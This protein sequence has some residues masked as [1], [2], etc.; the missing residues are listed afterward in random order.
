MKSS[1]GTVLAC[2]FGESGGATN[3]MVPRDLSERWI[4]HDFAGHFGVASSRSPIDR[5]IYRHLSNH[6]RDPC[7]FL[8]SNRAD[9]SWANQHL[10]KLSVG[11]MLH[12]TPPC[13]SNVPEKK[14]IENCVNMPE[15]ASF[16]CCNRKNSYSTPIACTTNQLPS[17]VPWNMRHSRNRWSRTSRCDGTCPGALDAQV[18][19]FPL[20]PVLWKTTKH[21]KSINVVPEASEFIS[22]HIT[23]Y[24]FASRYPRVKQ[25]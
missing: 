1:K 19:C 18:L 17:P 11:N 10:Q 4:S 2:I 15:S 23:S 3:K 24:Y 20:A 9:R 14:M 5:S 6:S 22:K 8:C 21:N 16:S 25:R 13:L 12:W 7:G